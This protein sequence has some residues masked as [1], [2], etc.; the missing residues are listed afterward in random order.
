MLYRVVNIE[1][2]FDCV[3]I[4]IRSKSYCKLL[5]SIMSNP[6]QT[7]NSAPSYITEFIH[8]NLSQLNEIFEKEQSERGP[9]CM[10]FLC[11]QETNKMDVSYMD[12][13]NMCQ[14]LREDSWM[15][16]Y[17]N[18]PQDKKLFFV[19][20]IDLNSVFLIYI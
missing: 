10:R 3:W 6:I 7:V 14:I 11:S 1:T 5:M 2:L 18:I 19:Q 17:Q 8:T 16:L 9:G 20:D 12:H 15:S 13:G 4:I